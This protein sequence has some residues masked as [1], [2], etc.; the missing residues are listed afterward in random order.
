MKNFENHARKRLTADGLQDWYVDRRVVGYDKIDRKL[1]LDSRD[2]SFGLVDTYGQF[3]LTELCMS[4]EEGEYQYLTSD[5]GLDI[6][7][8]EFEGVEVDFRGVVLEMARHAG[9]FICEA[10][11]SDLISLILEDRKRPLELEVISYFSPSEYNF[12]TDSCEFVVKQN[13]FDTVEELAEYLKNSFG[14]GDGQSLSDD[15]VYGMI[16]FLDNYIYENI[17]GYNIRRNGERLENISL[18]ELEK[19]YKK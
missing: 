17:T 1:I 14:G 18:D 7:S 15:Y 4:V 19:I 3:D 10:V 11:N 5:C 16:E 9:E 8:S 12:T 2:I 6:P 13:P